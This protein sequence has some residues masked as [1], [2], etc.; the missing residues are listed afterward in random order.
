[1]HG[2]EAIWCRC[3]SASV[4]ARPTLSHNRRKYLPDGRVAMQWRN[5]EH[6]PTEP[7][8]REYATIRLDRADGSTLAVL[9]NYAC[10]PVVMGRDNYQYSADYVGTACAVVEETAEN[11]VPVLARRLRQHQSLHGQDAAGPGRR[12]GDAEDGPHARRTARRR[13][14]AKRRPPCRPIRRSSTKPA[15][16]PSGFAGICKIREVRAILSKAYGPRFDNYL[17]KTI[18]NNHV[19][20]HAHD[21]C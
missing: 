4:A 15:R 2:G 5:A 9:F 3:G 6:E 7:V 21:A 19:A 17:S 18:K 13:R 14:P 12:R 8:D 16:F 10:H 11:Q 1:M 20:L